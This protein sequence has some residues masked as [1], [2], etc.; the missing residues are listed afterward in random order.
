MR[1]FAVVGNPLLGFQA[2][3]GGAQAVQQGQQRHRLAGGDLGLAAPQA[4][5]PA[6]RTR[7]LGDR[8]T[9]PN[10]STSAT[11]C[12]A[13]SG[14]PSAQALENTP[15]TGTSRLPTA[16]VPAGSSR[17]ARNHARYATH[18]ATTAT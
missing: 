7:C 14:S 2:L 18:C 5:K 10:V 4:L 9:P 3:R 6:G 17:S 8:T 16:A 13:P 15:I 12:R 11:R 1:P